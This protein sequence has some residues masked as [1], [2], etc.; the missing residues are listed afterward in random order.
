MRRFATAMVAVITA[1]VLAGC[2]VGGSKVDSTTYVGQVGA[3]DYYIAV[4]TDGHDVGAYLCDTGAHAFL[5]HGQVGGHGPIPLVSTNG[6]HV[7]DV[8][9][10][11]GKATGHL[12]IGTSTGP[13]TAELARGHAGYFRNL[14]QVN[15]KIVSDSGWIRLNDA[16]V[17]GA[18]TT[19]G[20]TVR[21]GGVQ[22]QQWTDPNV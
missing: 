10:A 18:K 15:G 17:H 4:L 16:T 6:V 13:F 1:A 3:T 12:T 2:S 14:E 19:G 11:K 20:T 21:A 8:T 7:G 9:I 5:L 22:G